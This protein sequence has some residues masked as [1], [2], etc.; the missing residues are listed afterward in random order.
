M[1]SL[2]RHEGYLLMDHRAGAGISDALVA[3]AAGPQAEMPVG[4]GKGLFECATYTCSHCQVVVVINPLRT[5]ERAYCRKCDHRICDTCGAIAA[6][7]GGE[8]KT[9]KELVEEVQ[10]KAALEIQ[11]QDRGIIISP[12]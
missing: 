2:K 3:L 7:N 1:P 12:T 5:R 8:C 6:S 10:E 11:A 4:A 9:F